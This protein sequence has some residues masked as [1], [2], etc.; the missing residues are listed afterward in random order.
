[1]TNVIARV[2]CGKGCDKDAAVLINTHFDSSLGTPGAMDTATPIGV[3]LEM[4]RNLLH[5]PITRHSAIFR[6]FSLLFS[7]SLSFD[8]V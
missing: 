5:R 2:S 4:V 6:L 3:M 1:M 8:C 7:L